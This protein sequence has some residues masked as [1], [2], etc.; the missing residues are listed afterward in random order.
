MSS[1]QRTVNECHLRLMK[2]FT[3]NN[4]YL[5]LI[6]ILLLIELFIV[7]NNNLPLIELFSF[8]SNKLELKKSFAV[9]AI[10]YY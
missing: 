5:T 6:T 2:L 1:L 3:V 9:N 4:N 10:I 7:N 8:D